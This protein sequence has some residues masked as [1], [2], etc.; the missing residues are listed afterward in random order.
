MGSG[1]Q[2]DTY[3]YGHF[4]PYGETTLAM[5]LPADRSGWTPDPLNAECPSRQVLDLV[6]DKWAVLVIAAIAEGHH[7]NGQLLRRVDG[8]SQKALTRSLR[9]LAYN[10][11]VLR[12]DFAEVPPH[13]E[14]TLT[15]TGESLQPLLALLCSW[16]IDHIDDVANAQA[17]ARHEAGETPA[18]SASWTAA[19]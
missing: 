11:L 13:V 6:A 12:N 18:T 8:I 2:S 19:R 9:D 4:C 15:P 1:A 10:G 7:R 5:P 3:K 14:Y 17:L 16:A